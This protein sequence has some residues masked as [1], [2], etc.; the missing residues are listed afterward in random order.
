MLN[1]KYPASI[2]VATIMIMGIVLVTALS[3]SAVSNKELKSSIGSSQSSKAYQNADSGIEQVLQLI[4]NFKDDK[5]DKIDDNC[6]GIVEFSDCT[7]QL[8][9]SAG[10][11]IEEDCNSTPVA[12][13]INIKS[14]GTS[15]NTQRAIEAPVVIN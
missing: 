4:K 7:V 10:E 15:G 8:M 3:I 2:L 1:K 5:I 14:I 9:D 11:I 6:D 13:I 12:D